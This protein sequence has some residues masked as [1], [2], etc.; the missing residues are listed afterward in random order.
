MPTN[1]NDT[2]TSAINEANTTTTLTADKVTLKKKKS[3]TKGKGRGDSYTQH[4]ML[5]LIVVMEEVLPISAIE[6][7][8]TR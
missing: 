7:E 2:T 8:T 6:W 4:E 3:T 1:I 5:D